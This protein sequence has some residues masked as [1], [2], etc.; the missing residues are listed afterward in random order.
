M[1]GA[2]HIPALDGVRG[3]AATAVLFSHFYVVRLPQVVNHRIGD[4]GVLLFFVL[5]GF[6]MGHL[7]LAHRPDRERLTHYGAARIAR[8]LPLYWGVGTIA[9]LVS[10]FLDPGFVYKV[11][12]V[13][14]VRI[15]SLTSVDA[16]FWSIGP[17]FQFYFLFPFFWLALYAQRFRRNAMIGIVA[18]ALLIYALSPWMPGFSVF[19]KLH[20]FLVGIGLAILR[21]A[22]PE[23]VA[24]RLALPLQLLGLAAILVIAF[25]PHALGDLVYPSTRDDPRHI[26]YYGDPLKLIACA[27]I[28]LGAALPGGFYG[29]LFG[30]R[31]MRALGAYSFSLYLLHLPVL[32]LLAKSGLMAG[33]PRPI[34]LL[35]AAGIAIAVAGASFH[36]LERPLGSA[37]RRGLTRLAQPVKGTAPVTP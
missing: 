21:M 36:L 6:L 7:Y 16:V 12:G 29:A 2:T 19:S 28:V 25:P 23:Q 34:A 26:A 8:V 33:A 30:N 37:V 10:H 22:M 13:G 20:I 31:A 35:S 24:T 11:D 18:G 32:Y 14:L 9:Y 3:M 27:A 4:Y 1:K 5:S 17:E 15:F